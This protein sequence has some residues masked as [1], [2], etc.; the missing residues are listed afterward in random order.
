LSTV[1]KRF[2]FRHRFAADAIE[3]QRLD[4]AFVA[5]ERRKPIQKMQPIT[6]SCSEETLKK[7]RPFLK[8]DEPW[9]QWI[10]RTGLGEPSIQQ[11][12]R[13]EIKRHIEAVEANK[14]NDP[15]AILAERGDFVQPR[16]RK[17]YI[18]V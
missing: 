13:D 8:K 4:A 9:L 10:A 15:S 12:S 1:F 5:A 7:I 2:P 11:M 17:F 16:P 18:E 14:E 6:P 3:Q